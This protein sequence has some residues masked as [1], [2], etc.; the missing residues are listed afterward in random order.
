[1]LRFHRTLLISNLTSGPR[2]NFPK[3]AFSY[4]ESHLGFL[5]FIFFSLLKENKNKW[6]L[7]TVFKNKIK[8]CLFSGKW[9]IAKKKMRGLH[10]S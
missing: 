2:L 8:S 4:K 10:L 3:H 6:Q 5:F 7:E 9:I 1:M